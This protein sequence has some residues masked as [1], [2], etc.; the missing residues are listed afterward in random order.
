MG[1]RAD[2][3]GV[4]AVVRAG[5]RPL[6]PCCLA[7]RR[8]P[9]GYFASPRRGAGTRHSH[10]A[11]AFPRERLVMPLSVLA[12]PVNVGT[13]LDGH[14]RDYVQLLVDA[15]DHAVVATPGAV[16]SGQA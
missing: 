15:V 14:D 13:V 5:F 16:Q 12:W 6:S 2:Q 8:P 1:L 3:A 10:A 11:E 9:S 7:R 4:A